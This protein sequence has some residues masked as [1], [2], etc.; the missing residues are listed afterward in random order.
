[1]NRTELTEVIK[2]NKNEK[3]AQLISESINCHQ[4]QSMILIRI[5]D[6]IFNFANNLIDQRLYVNQQFGI[7]NRVGAQGLEFHANNQ[8]VLFTKVK[9]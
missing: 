4:L 5:T 7:S 2:F 1:M 8:Y 9:N 3:N 6:L